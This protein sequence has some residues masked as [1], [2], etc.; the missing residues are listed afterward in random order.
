MP[1]RDEDVPNYSKEI[2]TTAVVRTFS[3]QNSVFK[4]WK[5]DTSETGLNCMKHDLEL[6]QAD[7][8]IKNEQ[9]L[10]DTADVMRKYAREI[11]N[12]FI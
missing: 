6:W 8:F 4:D 10:A 11:K 1:K 12:I 5:E 2:K 9:D 7:K 3:K